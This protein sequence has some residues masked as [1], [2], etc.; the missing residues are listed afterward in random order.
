MELVDRSSGKAMTVSFFDS[1]E[2]MRAAEPTCEEELPRRL[3]E[4]MGQWVGR[5]TSVERYEVAVDERTR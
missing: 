4:F 1:E 2:N 5:R 3:G